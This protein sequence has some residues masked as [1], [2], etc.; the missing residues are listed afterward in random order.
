MAFEYRVPGVDLDKVVRSFTDELY[1]N[2]QIQLRR[3]QFLDSQYDRE[4]KLYSGKLRNQDLGEFESKFSAY[5]QAGMNMQRANR[6]RGGN[7][8]QAG[9]S[10]EAAKADMLD[11]QTKS[12]ELGGY[13]KNLNS[14]RS[15]AKYLVDRDQLDGVLSDASTLTNSEFR[16]KYG[17]EANEWPKVDDF[18]WKPEK[19]DDT[20]NQMDIKK[21]LFFKPNTNMNVYEPKEANG[22]RKMMDVPFEINGVQ[23]TFKVPVLTVAANPNAS[24]VLDRVQ[25][26]SFTPSVK[27]FYEW[28][29]NR[30]IQ[31][32]QDDSNPALQ[33]QAQK[34]LDFA[35]KL[36]NQDVDKLS[37]EEIYAASF[38][39]P[40][41]PS[42]YDIPDM[43]FLNQ[44][45]KMEMQELNKLKAQ[46]AIQKLNQ[47]LSNYAS[48]WSVKLGQQYVN[49][50]KGLAE[51]GATASDEWMTQYEPL[52]NMV[53]LPID[54]ATRNFM[55]NQAIQDRL[56]RQYGLPI[57]GQQQPQMYNPWMVSPPAGPKTNTKF[58]SLL[59][60]AKGN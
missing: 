49:L 48:E 28:N 56:N 15:Q 54:Q 16:D 14:I 37:A 18:V 10:K 32:S 53:N 44:Q 29:K 42:S 7:V 13:F 4:F 12:A 11:Y 31:G 23:K 3:Q 43:K 30:L 38:I 9:V 41:R 34:T 8:T 17:K 26:T 59:P 40:D 19:Y 35:A 47:D 52:F 55:Y 5:K 24:D 45:M 25:R 1:R 60:R 22:Q 39:N 51:I 58:P 6:G 27:N 2:S 21:T 36:F 46:K 57:Q 33:Q 50:Y 20:K